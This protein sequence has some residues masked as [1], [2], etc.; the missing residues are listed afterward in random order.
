VAEEPRRRKI[1]LPSR[2]F[3]IFVAI[4]IVLAAMAVPGY[5]SSCRASRER[6][7]STR[8]KDICNAEA[9]F[10]ANDRDEN[11]IQDYWTGDVSGLSRTGLLESTLVQADA[12]PLGTLHD[13]GP[14]QG[15]S[16]MAMD[17][18]ESVTPTAT[19][20]TDTDKSGRKVHNLERFGFCAYPRSG[21]D[22][23]Y[24][25]IVNE[26]STIFRFEGVTALKSW[27]KDAV[28]RTT[29]HKDW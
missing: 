18:D 6:H 9:D 26:N 10:R 11:K 24:C 29:G 27:P 1:W 8:L 7:A 21:W 12:H 19:Y 2:D 4:G 3:L 22:G 16:F 15:C 25:F 13:A 17:Q 28:V 20:R 23:K 14:E 5:L